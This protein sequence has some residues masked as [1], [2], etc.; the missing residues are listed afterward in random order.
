V[1]WAKRE[2]QAEN[3]W[4][5]KKMEKGFLKFGLRS[6]GADLNFNQMD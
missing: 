4:A 1:D 6:L 5:A 2:N 3:S